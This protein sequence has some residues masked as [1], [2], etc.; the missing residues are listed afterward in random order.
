MS[1]AGLQTT[2]GVGWNGCEKPYEMAQLMWEAKMEFLKLSIVCI[3]KNAEERK[4]HEES[5]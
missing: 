4:P 2:G 5:S 3:Q 1:N